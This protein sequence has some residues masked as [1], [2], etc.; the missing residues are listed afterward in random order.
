MYV[1]VYTYIVYVSI[2][3]QIHTY[4]Y[5]LYIDVNNKKW[6]HNKPIS[7]SQAEAPVWVLDDRLNIHSARESQKS[8]VEYNIII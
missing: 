1:S 5:T 4:V 7:S 2:N 8:F 6:Q 3:K